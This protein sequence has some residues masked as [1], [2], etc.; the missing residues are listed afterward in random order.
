[1]ALGDLLVSAANRFQ[2]GGSPPAISARGSCRPGIH[3]RGRHDKLSSGLSRG[4]MV[5]MGKLRVAVV[6]SLTSM[7]VGE[8]GSLAGARVTGRGAYERRCGTVDHLHLPYV[9]FR[10]VRGIGVGCREARRVLLRFLRTPQRTRLF[11]GGAPHL[12]SMKTVARVG[13]WRCVAYFPHYGPPLGPG[14]T[15]CRK[16]SRIIQGV[17]VP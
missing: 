14:Y 5:R 16:A 1:V 6:I 15:T 11:P 9:A 7:V 17:Y 10:R 3:H 8:G 13:G 2:G 4:S 12:R